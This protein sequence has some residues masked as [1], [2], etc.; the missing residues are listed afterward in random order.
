[1]R[2]K[3]STSAGSNSI[4]CARIVIAD[5]PSSATESS[6]PIFSISAISAAPFSWPRRRRRPC[7]AGGQTAPASARRPPGSAGAR[8]AWPRSWSARSTSFTGRPESDCGARIQSEQAAEARRWRARRRRRAFSIIIARGEL[9]DRAPAAAP[10]RGSAP[11]RSRAAVPMSCSDRDH[12]RGLVAW[13]R[14]RAAARRCTQRAVLSGGVSMASKK[15]ELALPSPTRATFCCT[16]LRSS[17][18]KSAGEVV[19]CE[20]ARRLRRRARA[21]ADVGERDVRPLASANTTATRS[22]SNDA[23]EVVGGHGSSIARASGSRRAGGAWPDARGLGAAHR[24]Q[25]RAGDGLA[26]LHA[27]L[28]EGDSRPR[29]TLCTKTLCS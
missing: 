21:K 17:A 1:M 3:C 28:V 7:R 10:R 25:D 19:A 23:L 26:Q 27:A 13:H 20:L 15:A 4:C 18:A 29:S 6:S 5:M 2:W 9:L 14:A 24:G 22:D 8:G 12:A 11:R 16:R